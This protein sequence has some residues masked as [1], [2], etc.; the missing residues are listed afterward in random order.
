VRLRGKGL[1]PCSSSGSNRSGGK[2]M[3]HHQKSLYEYYFD[4]IRI[5]STQKDVALKNILPIDNLRKNSKFFRIR[6]PSSKAKMS[7]FKSSLEIVAPTKSFLQILLQHERSLKTYYI[8][9]IEIAKDTSCKT[10]NDADSL[11]WERLKTVRKKYSSDHFIYDQ[12][13]EGP[14]KKRTNNHELFG[15]HTGYFGGKRFEYVTYARISKINGLPCL[16]EEWAIN[17]AQTIKNKT[18]IS[19]ISDLCV[20]DL[21]SFFEDQYDKHIVHENIDQ[22]K[23]GKWVLGCTRIKKVSKRK[24]ISI[25]VNAAHFCEV[26]DIYTYGDLV[27]FFKKKKA[28]IKSRRGRRSAMDNKILSLKNYSKFRKD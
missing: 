19:S 12:R 22:Q 26:N 3:W 24:F 23:L 4:K 27:K 13:K 7:R 1:T 8:S 25:G 6:Y 14:E 17:G 11:C 15:K 5:N 10:K 20:F 28:E 21:K 2:K 18:M 16:H 9:Y